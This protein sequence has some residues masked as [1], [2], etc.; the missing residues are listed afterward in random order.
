MPRTKG[1]SSSHLIGDGGHEN[2]LEFKCRLKAMFTYVFT[3]LCTGLGSCTA[4]SG[5]APLLAIRH[6]GVAITRVLLGC[7]H[8][9]CTSPKILGWEKRARTCSMYFP[10]V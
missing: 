7:L 4:F 5:V 2:R 6:G 8:C 3:N 10:G 1:L 9:V